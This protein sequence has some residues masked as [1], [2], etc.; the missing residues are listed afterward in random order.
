MVTNFH[1][2]QGGNSFQVTLADG[3]A[4]RARLVGS[5]PSKDLAV[6]QIAAPEDGLSPLELGSSHDLVVGQKVLAVGNP[7]GLD[8]TLT[9]GVISA[10][11]R[12]IPSV[13]GT[14]IRDVIQ[15]DASINPGNSGGP[16]LDSKGR[17]IGINTAIY[18]PSGAS[19]GIGFAVPVDTIRRIVPDLIAHGVVKR[20][21]LGI[22]VLSDHLSSRLAPSGVVV[23]KVE[24]N[25][26]AARAGLQP[27]RT[28]LFGNVLGFDL[29]LE[30]D[31][32]PLHRYD[33]LFSALEGRKAGEEVTLRYARGSEE[34]SV[35]LELVPLN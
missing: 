23:H 29:L 33:D 14:T 22:T 13:I 31:G 27:L 7:F 26:P 19:A 30:L 15:T 4:L 9:T 11:G 2:V 35:R 12:E 21:G 8:H 28:D 5:E 1:V 20:I 10:L 34:R 18:S 3:T 17:L 6:L 32:A 24:P 25:S 16:L